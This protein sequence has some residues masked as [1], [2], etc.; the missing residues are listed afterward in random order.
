M[1]KLL[2]ALPGAVI[3]LAVTASAARAQ[4][5]AAEIVGDVIDLS[6][7]PVP[8]AALTVT[9][10]GTKNERRLTADDR[11][12][13]MT[14]GLVPGAYH[15]TA[16]AQ[17]FAPRRQ[18]DLVLA[19]N[20]RAT[21]RLAL[22][23]AAMP[24]TLTVA[25]VPAKLETARSDLHQAIEA[26]QLENLP[27]LHRDPFALSELV[28]ATTVNPTDGQPRVMAHDP[29]LNGYT[30]DGFNRQDSL[31]GASQVLAPLSAIMA[32]DE[33]IN[34]YTAEAG[35]AA[36]V[37]NIAT[38]TGTN[39]LHGSLFDFFSDRSLNGLKTIDQA[40]GTRPPY[41]SNQF[42]GVV[43]GP[44]VVNRDFFLLSYEGARQTI[45][46]GASVDFSPFVSS[47]PRSTAALAQLRSLATRDAR[48]WDRDRWML[49]TNHEFNGGG[50]LRLQYAERR[51]DGAAVAA[52]GPAPAVATTGD[53]DTRARMF[54]ALLGAAAG[55]FVNEARVQYATDHD[56]EMAGPP[57][58]T[59]FE[60]GAL[61]LRTGDS[62][63]GPH[64]FKTDQIQVSD[65]VSIANGAHAAKAGVEALLD[66]NDLNPNALVRGSYVFQ[67][68]AS[69]AGGAP[70][71][72][73]ES[74]TQTFAT[75][76]SRHRSVD[77]RTYS[78]FVQDTW[79]ISSVATADVGLRY[80]TQV[81]T[82][83]M[84]RDPDNWAPRVGLAIRRGEHAVIRSGYGLYYGVTPALIPAIALLDSGLN[85]TTVTV[86][87]PAA[88]AYPN[89]LAR[90]PVTPR[91][92]TVVDTQFEDARIHQ[93]NIGYAW[94]KYRVGTAD[95]AYV[96]ARGTHLPRLV[97]ANDRDTLVGFGR[98]AEYESTGESLYNAL[99]A[100]G[101]LTRTVLMFD[102]AYTFARMEATPFGVI[103]VQPGTIGD[104]NVLAQT[105]QER[106]SPGEDDHHHHLAASMVYDT[107]A[108]AD[109]YHGITRKLLQ[110]WTLSFTYD[111]LSGAP[112][113]AYAD[114]DLNGDGNPFNDVAPATT[115]NQY[116]LPWHI[117][118]NPRASRDFHFGNGRKVSFIWEA[119]NLT[120]RPNYVAVDDMLYTMTPT[121]LQRNPLF[122]RRTAVDEGRVMQ[123]AA[124]V[125]F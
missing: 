56:R 112:Y 1:N 38:R 65:T 102:V 74:Y 70:G 119:F 10:V 9:N 76:S 75:D 113:T 117:S 90:V 83:G 63:L 3:V 21:V 48:G 46:G 40:T 123:L 73:G 89:L 110:N 32:F 64:D 41:L 30:V 22:R 92:T 66:Q 122:G 95:I 109:L 34:G 8:R 105:A 125:T 2:H 99:T 61:V 24:E 27:D 45:A 12:R 52:A 39:R 36:G 115:R 68:L 14:T 101:R 94:E 69:F 103:S 79:R 120:N 97:E 93:A 86:G 37:F 53:V 67:S 4:T 78:A 114:A 44:L 11:G 60:R 29:S 16:K 96:F 88:P 55:G 98:V 106:R 20:Q 91:S 31:T 18:E 80:D 43:G 84:P 108:R 71:G 49:K 111:A 72:T 17:G 62:A 15:V 82:G 23:R 51:I 19:P 58:V 54:G 100:R 13:F 26:Q 87:G 6:G 77:V 47:D 107:N 59:V 42:G 121:G 116:R 118:L 85:T 25:E 57:A 33:R 35:G 28:V 50:T 7:A 124:K 5:G 104:R 81:F